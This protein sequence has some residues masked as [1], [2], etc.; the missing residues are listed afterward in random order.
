MKQ[1]TSHSK[2]SS[3]SISAHCLP[4][5]AAPAISSCRFT[6]A[7]EA[8]CQCSPSMTVK[9]RHGFRHPVG[10]VAIQDFKFAVSACDTFRSY[11]AGMWFVLCHG[12][13]CAVKQAF[14]LHV[15]YSLHS[16]FTV[17]STQTPSHCIPFLI[18]I[19]YCAVTRT[20]LHLSKS[21]S[22]PNIIITS[23]PADS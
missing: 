1:T 23:N 20:L 8:H 2:C 13:T 6:G 7:E 14:V 12:F 10:T 9:P 18:V 21:P 3:D 22:P 17:T 19:T 15:R 4:T 5:L 16:N 11:C